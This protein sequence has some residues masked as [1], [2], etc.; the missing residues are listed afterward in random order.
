MADRAT[1]AS[2]NAI[3]RSPTICF[4]L[5]AFAGDEQTVARIQ[6]LDGG[7]DG[8]GAVAD[9]HRAGTGVEDRPP[10]Q[11][12]VFAAG[13]VVG[14]DD[15]VGE[16][17]CNLAHLPPL[18]D[19]P[20]AAAAEDHDERARHQRTQGAQRRR[21]RVGGVRIIHEDARP[22][23]MAGNPL[24]PAQHTLECIERLARVRC[25]NA[26]RKSKADGSQHVM[27]LV[28]AGERQS[29]FV[30]GAQ[31]RDAQIL[32]GLRYRAGPA[33]AGPSRRSRT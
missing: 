11:C 24:Q 10:D 30:A 17:G 8:P 20:L 1:S 4:L 6:P 16:P 27:G 31:D 18:A 21:Q 9:L 22:G 3:A 14:N 13:V 32:A 15:S 25:A 28:G 2:S 5:V 12:R 26:R 33:A 19:I 23:R 29:D 7:A